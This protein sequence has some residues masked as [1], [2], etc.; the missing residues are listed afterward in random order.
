MRGK[1]GWAVAPGS[2]RPDGKRWG[3]TNLATAYRNKTIPVLPDWL[4]NIIRPPRKTKLEA[5]SQPSA[6][7]EMARVE[8][9]LALHP[10]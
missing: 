6:S 5:K 1:G 2:L 7:E 9:R 8:F 3:R 4:A 10:E